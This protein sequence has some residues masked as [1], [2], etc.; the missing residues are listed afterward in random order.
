MPFSVCWYSENWYS[1]NWYSENWYSENWS[2]EDHTS[3]K[4][5]KKLHSRVYLENSWHFERKV[6]L[7]EDC[8][9]RHRVLCLQFHLLAHA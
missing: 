4:D 5:V 7:A 9:L 3:I 2:S 1:E 8:V 6:R